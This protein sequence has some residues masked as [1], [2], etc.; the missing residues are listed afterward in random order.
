MLTMA[1]T[2]TTIT[3]TTTM[4][5]K[6]TSIVPNLPNVDGMGCT[7]VL[8]G[9]AFATIILVTIRPFAITMVGIVVATPATKI[10]P[11]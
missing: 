3:T 9:M 7:R 10:G 6:A 5:M 2:T 1:I 4:P 8:W 11:L